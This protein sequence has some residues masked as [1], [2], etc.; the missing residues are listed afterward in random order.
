M[1]EDALDLLLVDQLADLL[2]HLGLVDHVGNLAYDDA[3]AAVAVVSISVRARINTRR[4][5]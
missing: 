5:P 1:Y 2:N 3:L 4:D